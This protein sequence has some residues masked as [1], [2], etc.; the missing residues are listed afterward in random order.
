MIEADGVKAPVTVIA[1]AALANGGF[2]N[3][4]ICHRLTTNNIYVYNVVIQLELVLAAQTL[5]TG[6]K[7]FP[8]QLRQITQPG[9]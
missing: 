8:K 5:V 6:M 3:Q 2:Y 9:L 4:T 7:T 1:L